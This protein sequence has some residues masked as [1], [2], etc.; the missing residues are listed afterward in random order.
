M[1]ICETFRL[2]L[3][4]GLAPLFLLGAAACGP[5]KDP[6]ASATAPAASEQPV[7]PLA[8]LDGQWRVTAIDGRKAGGIEL[9]SDG[10]SLW[11]EPGCAGQG[12]RFSSDGSRFKTL[13]PA[14]GGEVCDIGLPDDLAVVWA[15]LDSADSFTM[16]GAD[17]VRI[18][19][20]T[21]GVELQRV[22][23]PATLAGEWRVAGIDGVSFDEPVGLALSANGREVWWNPRCAGLVRRY[24][25]DGRNFRAGPQP[26]SIPPP[27]PGTPPP[28]VCAIGLPPHL[29]EAVRA[30]DSATQIRR[31]PSNGIELTGG[32]HSLLM[33]A[34]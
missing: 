17:S 11:W 3:R 14:P 23:G 9:W 12:R 1:A 5:A 29:V 4:Q 26:S 20:G 33:Y 21:E 8:A 19:K 16:Q 2:G 24:T 25:I 31:T 6:A 34:Q 13:P 32:G 30:I 22:P 27:P 28:P 10:K 18:G 15:R 7:R